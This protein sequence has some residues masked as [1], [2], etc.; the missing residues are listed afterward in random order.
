[1]EVPHL[2]LSKQTDTD[3]L[4]TGEDQYPR[5]DEDRTVQVHNV[6]SS[7]QLQNQQPGS[8]TEAGEGAEGADGSEEVQ[9][10]RHVFE[11]KADREQ[12]EEDPEST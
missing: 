4:N 10:P 8:E 9:G 1:M 3:H 6:L 11:Q 5:D 12:V 2:K 7:Q